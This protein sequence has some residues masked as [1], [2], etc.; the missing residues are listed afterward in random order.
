MF[1]VCKDSFTAL[2]T[3]ATVCDKQGHKGKLDR[4]LYYI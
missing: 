3:Y 4:V 2:E 1:T